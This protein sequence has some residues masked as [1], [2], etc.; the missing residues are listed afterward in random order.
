[1]T[2]RPQ[3]VVQTDLSFD[4]DYYCHESVGIVVWD[5]GPVK[6]HYE[7][8][9]A[10]LICDRS[11]VD[12]YAWLAKKFGREILKGSTWG[13]HISF[14]RSEKPINISRWGISIGHVPFRYAHTIRCDNDFHAWVDVWC[15]KLHEIRA[16]LGL[17][18]KT[19]QSFH[20]TLGR[21]A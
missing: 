6:K 14:V 19:K 15:P 9:W 1:M 13:P 3:Y 7:P 20:L 18:P 17:P 12:Y 8:W 2:L 10:R 16:E 4:S 21:L 5:N 11:I